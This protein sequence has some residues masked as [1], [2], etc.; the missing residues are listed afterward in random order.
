MGICCCCC[1]GSCCFNSMLSRSIEIFIIVLN[2]ISFILVL[3]SLIV[4]KWKEL[5]NSNLYFFIAL[6]V[7]SIVDLILAIFLRYWSSTGESK[8]TKKESA[9]CL[10]IFGLTL[11]VIQF[12]VCLIEE[13]VFTISFRK[14]NYPCLNYDINDYYDP[15]Y[16]RRMS[17][18]EECEKYGSSY[19][20]EI[21]SVGQNLLAYLT[22][23][24]LE[25]ALIF[26]MVL[27][28]ILRQRIP[29]GL[30]GPVMR[31]V[32]QVPIR[33]EVYVVQPGYQV[34]QYQQNIPY[35]YN[36]QVIPPNSNEYQTRN[37]P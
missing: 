8:T 22:L 12:I 26:L 2:C 4:V 5:S 35:G 19:N 27:W 3:F 32:Q 18:D 9:N 24:Y 23:S 7:L 33:Q 20:T 25:I 13:V 1:L 31:S 6:L 14:V 34:F 29:S 36:Q 30:D 16:Y 10:S 15:Y 21:I 17:Y 37:K 11:S 28:A